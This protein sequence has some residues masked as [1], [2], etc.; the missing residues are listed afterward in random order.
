[1][2]KLKLVFLA[3]LT[4]LGA[5]AGTA[6]AAVDPDGALNPTTGDGGGELF[7]SVIDRGGPVQRS[8]VLDLGITAADLLANDASLVNNLSFTADAGLLD[9]IN[10]RSG[11]LAW[12]IAAAHNFPGATNDDFG[13]L[14]TSPTALVA[15]SNTPIGFNGISIALTKVGTYALAVNGT[16]TD[17]ATDISQTFASTSGAYYDVAWG[18]MWN[19]SHSTEGALGDSLGFYFVAMDFNESDP[20]GDPTLYSRVQALLGQWTLSAGGLLSYS[21]DIGPAPV[22]VP[23]AVWLLGSALVGM[24][25]IGRRR[26]TA[27]RAANDMQPVAA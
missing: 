27:E 22:P 9:I 16:N 12:N 20:S 21:A 19:G 23:A 18:D 11:T 25:G 24:V 2:K 1:M 3:S 4:A 26:K 5:A 13:Y 14:T 10:N 7:L 17:Y 6:S 8:Y 15:N